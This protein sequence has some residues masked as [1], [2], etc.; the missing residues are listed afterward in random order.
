VTT[1]S[2]SIHRSGIAAT[3][4]VKTQKAATQILL[5][6]EENVSSCSMGDDAFIAP[7]LAWMRAVIYER[8]SVIIAQA[9]EAHFN[10]EAL[11]ARFTKK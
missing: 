1:T 9:N 6:L 2:V 8:Q 10:L 5:R 7:E 4:R 11:S 3:S